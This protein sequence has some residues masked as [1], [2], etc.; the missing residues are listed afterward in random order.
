M[1]SARVSIL[2]AIPTML[3]FIARTSFARI[4]IT[5]CLNVRLF[6]SSTH[7][8]VRSIRPLSNLF[9]TL[10]QIPCL[11][12]RVFSRESARPVN[13]KFGNCTEPDS[14]FNEREISL[15]LDDLPQ[16]VQNF[17]FSGSFSLP[18]SENPSPEQSCRNSDQGSVE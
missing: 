15:L 8:M 13:G 18:C 14:S 3:L 1:L 6:T 4:R 9:S 5:T 10:Y 7:R 11:R 12:A 16:I 17:L 2:S